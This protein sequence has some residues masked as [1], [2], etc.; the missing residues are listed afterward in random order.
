MGETDENGSLLSEVPPTETDHA[1]ESRPVLESQP[2][3]TD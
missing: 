1:A 2:L 3:N